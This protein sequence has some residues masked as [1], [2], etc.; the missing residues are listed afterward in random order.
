MDTMMPVMDG[1][2]A[3]RRIRQL[4]HGREVLILAVSAS[5]AQEDRD[6]SLAAGANAFIAKPIAHEVLLHEM[7]ARMG[8]RWIYEPPRGQ[9][10]AEEENAQALIPPPQEQLEVLH[11]LALAGSM[12]DILHWVTQLTNLGEQ[13]GPFATKVS[14]LARGYQSKAILG[15]V[16]SYMTDGSRQRRGITGT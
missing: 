5:A 12:R 3:T 15:L 2:E 1:L 11:Q 13:Y 6:R 9:P 16:E 10:A 14:Q 4:P 8:L 7:G